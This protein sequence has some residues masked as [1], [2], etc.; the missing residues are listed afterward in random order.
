ME[1]LFVSGK[2]P[3]KFFM[4][5]CEEKRSLQ[6]LIS[7]HGGQVSRSYLPGCIELVPYEKDFR[8]KAENAKKHPVY[9]FKLIHDSVNLG[10]MQDLQEYEIKAAYAPGIKK[11][12]ARK[13]YTPEEDAEIL[14]YVEKNP[15]KTGS[16]KYWEQALASGLSSE[17]SAESLRHHWKFHKPKKENVAEKTPKPETPSPQKKPKTATPQ[18]FSPGKISVPSR[19]SSARKKFTTPS[20]GG[21]DLTSMMGSAKSNISAMAEGFLKLG[22]RF[23]D[24]NQIKICVSTEGRKVADM[25]YLK[26]KCIDA[27]I[28]EHFMRL[29]DVCKQHSG[30]ELQEED[31]ARILVSNQGRVGATVSYFSKK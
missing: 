17:H 1:K 24:H 26:K 25:G 16:L 18:S 12:N 8:L 19:S 15:G 14:A 2:K 28:P 9:S 22:S 23:E 20:G 5:T 10:E 13:K 29:V 31:V 7:K 11:S 30:K 27:K 3:L 21:F 4:E 6:K